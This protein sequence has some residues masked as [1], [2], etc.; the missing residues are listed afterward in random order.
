MEKRESSGMA[1]PVRRIAKPALSVILSLALA[2]LITACSDKE[3]EPKVHTTDSGLKYEILTEGS[4]A[5]PTAE[6]SVTVHYEGTLMD[7]TKFDSSYDRGETITFPLN[8]VIKGWTE[9][10]QLMKEGAK[11]KFTIPS[12]L[13]YG[14]EGGGP[15]PPNADLIFIVELVK[16]VVD[17][18]KAFLKQNKEKSGIE[19]TDSGLQYKILL[20]GTGKSPNAT[21]RVTVHYEG[22]LI[23]GTK[24]DS[25]YDRGE[26]IDFGL[27][28]VIPGWTEGVQLMKEG[29]KYKFFIPSELAYGPQGSPGAIPPNAALIF[30]VELIR[31]N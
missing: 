7:G 23:D 12:D 20:E 14:E 16:V 5:S 24:F 4:G 9:G 3:K 30:T 25:S 6:D 8:R 31:V 18:G 21:D 27:N 10:V 11:Y 19:T 13:A 29:A 15:I 2:L 17:E 1:A 22:T 26:P 28:Q